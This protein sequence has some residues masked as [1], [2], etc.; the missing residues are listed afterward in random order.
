MYELP[1]TCVQSRT[2][3]ARRPDVIIHIIEAGRARPT[4]NFS[5]ASSENASITG[6]KRI[7]CKKIR[8][9]RRKPHFEI[10]RYEHRNVTLRQRA[11]GDVRPVSGP[12]AYL[13]TAGTRSM[14]SFIRNILD[15]RVPSA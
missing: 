7:C 2:Q 3:E 4:F 11:V 10:Q 13:K 1:R 15:C 8:R 12:P 5:Y 6:K 14:T 9:N